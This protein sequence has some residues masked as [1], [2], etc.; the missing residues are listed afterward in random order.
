MPTMAAA[1]V[2]RTPWCPPPAP[3]HTTISQL[4]TRHVYVLKLE[5]IHFFTIQ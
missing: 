3:P 5:I 1:V 4:A 2:P